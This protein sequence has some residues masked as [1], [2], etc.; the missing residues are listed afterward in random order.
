M[1]SRTLLLASLVLLAACGGDSGPTNPGGIADKFSA[2]VTGDANHDMS[3]HAVYAINSGVGFGLE[4]VD[5]TQGT[6]YF[7]Q[8][9][10]APSSGDNTLADATTGEVGPG[11]LWAVVLL[12]PPA[13]PA[14]GMLY[15]KSG[16]ITITSQSGDELK[17]NFSFTATGT[18]NGVDGEATVQVS[19]SFD[20]KNGSVSTPVLRI[21]RID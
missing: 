19:G 20:A 13:G 18:V 7:E 5:T 16:T 9:Q 6:L 3:G 2:S 4:L 15:S 10:G 11:S 8:Q 12:T 14:E 21:E 1:L 17:G